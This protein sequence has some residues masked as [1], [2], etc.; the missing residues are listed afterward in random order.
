MVA[1]IIF[2]EKDVATKVV[3]D[4]VRNGVM[5]MNTWSTSI[6]MGPPL[7][8]TV[9]ALEESFD[10]VERSIKRFEGGSN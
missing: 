6:K 8:I 7:T 3:V 4:C 2:H 9:E 5:V 10:V 1:G